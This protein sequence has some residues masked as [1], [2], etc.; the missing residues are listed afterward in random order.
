MSGVIGTGWT[1][2][3]CALIFGIEL[4][5]EFSADRNLFEIGCRGEPLD[6]LALGFESRPH[7]VVAAP[8]VVCLLTHNVVFT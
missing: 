1:H 7:R 5:D 6:A 8:V 4:R 3:N 2:S